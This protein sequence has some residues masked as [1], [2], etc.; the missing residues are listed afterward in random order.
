MTK[1][2]KDKLILG[3]QVGEGTHVYIRETP[4]GEVTSGL[5]SRDKDNLPSYD[6]QITLSQVEGDLYE[7]DDEVMFTARGVQEE[8][9]PPIVSTPQYRE[10]WDRIF[11][12]KPVVGQA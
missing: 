5:V 4:D 6:S 12:K 10:G 2:D 11:G 3:P 9:G 8:S 7:V 1:K